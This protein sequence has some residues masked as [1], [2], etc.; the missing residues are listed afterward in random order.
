[1]NKVFEDFVSLALIDH[2][3]LLGETTA[4]YRVVAASDGRRLRDHDLYVIE[5][6]GESSVGTTRG[7]RSRAAR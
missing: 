4:A 3:A 7:N 5:T 6:P 1:M 2:V